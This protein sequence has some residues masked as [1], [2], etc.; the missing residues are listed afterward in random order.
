MAMLIATTEM[1]TAMAVAERGVVMVGGAARQAGW[2]RELHDSPA[3]DVTAGLLGEMN[4]LPGR[5]I[6]EEDDMVTVRL[7]CG[8][9]VEARREDA[10]VGAECVVCV[11]PGRIAI[12]QAAM[13]Q[14]SGGIMGPG[15]LSGRVRAQRFF[16]DIVWV[17]LEIGTERGRKPAP[18]GVARPAVV[19]MR[20]EVGDAVALAWQPQYAMAFRPMHRA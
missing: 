2:L 10:P 20:L 5:V 9:I 18:L 14:D 11:R 13:A 19:P 8:P 3:D 6:S 12:A 16:G 17:D 15:A 7:D 4:R 1:H